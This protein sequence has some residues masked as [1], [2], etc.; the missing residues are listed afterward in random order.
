MKVGDAEESKIRLCSY[1]VSIFSFSFFF[2]N[3]WLQI[4]GEESRR[5]ENKEWPVSFVNK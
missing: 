4:D 1:I 3:F 5:T 2:F